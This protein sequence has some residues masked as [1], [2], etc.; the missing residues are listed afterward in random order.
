MKKLLSKKSVA[1]TASKAVEEEG[2]KKLYALYVKV[3]GRLWMTLSDH[4]D[5]DHYQTMKVLIDDDEE[6]GHA[7]MRHCPH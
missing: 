1:L 7:H 4:G 2:K 6:D 5:T 3:K